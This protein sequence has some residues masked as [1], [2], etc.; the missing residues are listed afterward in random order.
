MI[1]RKDAPPYRPAT[2]STYTPRPRAKAV[3]QVDTRDKLVMQVPKADVVRDE[4]YRRLVATLKCINCGVVGRTQCAHANSPASG[5]G[6]SLKAD[7]RE[8]FP[9]CLECHQKFDQGALF[10]K[11]QRREIE[12]L[13]ANKTRMTLRKLAEFDAGARRIVHRVL[14]P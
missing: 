2:Q 9:L 6:L 11:E 12:P 5:K 1:R 14:G 13:W 7:D 8:V 3:A 4:G 10:T